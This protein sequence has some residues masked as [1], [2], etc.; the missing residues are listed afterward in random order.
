MFSIQIIQMKLHWMKPSFTFP[1]KFGETL[2]SQWQT[3]LS[4]YIKRETQ[5]SAWDILSTFSHHNTTL[6]KRMRGASQPHKKRKKTKRTTERKK[7]EL[8]LH[9]PVGLFFHQCHSQMSS[10]LRAVHS[11]FFVFLALVSGSELLSFGFSEVVKVR[12]SLLLASKWNAV[13]GRCRRNLWAYG[14][15]NDIAECSFLFLVVTFWRFPCDCTTKANSF[16]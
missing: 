8:L 1:T 7:C 14:Q 9:A 6:T 16:R 5:F 2:L 4:L 11:Q 13:S 15:L 3:V 12:P 10:K